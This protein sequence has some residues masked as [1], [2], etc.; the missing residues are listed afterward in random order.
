MDAG[1]LG[2]G[3]RGRSE[4][5]AERAIVSARKAF[6]EGPWP[7]MGRAERAAAIHRLADLMEER[8]DDLATMD[9]TNMG[10]PFLQAKHDVAPLGVELPVLRRPPA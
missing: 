9:A 5:D 7:R 2:A 1:G 3:R 4:K 6:D 10:K 8:A